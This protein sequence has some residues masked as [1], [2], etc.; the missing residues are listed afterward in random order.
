[1]DFELVFD[2]IARFNYRNR[3]LVLI[4]TFT[5]TL[6]FSL[7]LIN[8]RLESDPQ[9]L[10]VSHDSEGYKQEMDFDDRYGAFFRT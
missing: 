7:G 5:I 9:E 3:F 10:W 4:A 8:I 1:M 6:I 2:K